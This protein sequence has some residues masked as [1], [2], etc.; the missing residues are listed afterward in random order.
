MLVAGTRSVDHRQKDLNLVARY[1]EQ[2]RINVMNITK[3]TC[4]Y[5]GTFNLEKLPLLAKT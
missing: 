3:E 1:I 4:G 5:K 2:M